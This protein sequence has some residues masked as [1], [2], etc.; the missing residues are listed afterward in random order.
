MKNGQE[1]RGWIR[2]VAMLVLVSLLSGCQ[3]IGGLFSIFIDPLIPPKII[4]AQHDMSAK[5]VLVWVDD[6]QVDSQYVLLRRTLTEAL[7]QELLAHQGVSEVIDYERIA[8]FRVTH[9]NYSLMSIEELGQKFQADE[10]L[11]VFINDFSWQHDAGVGFY[12]PRLGGYIKVIDAQEG[13]QRLWPKDRTHQT[14]QVKGQLEQGDGESFE[15]N[16]LKVFSQM[17][18]NRLTKYFYAHPEK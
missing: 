4:A 14:F 12:Q 13:G 17:V 3:T 8:R 9:P 18:A 16:L 6:P 1:V 11:Y 2:V 15:K 7:Q 10:V 5:R